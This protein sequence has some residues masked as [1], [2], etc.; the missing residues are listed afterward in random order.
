[1]GNWHFITCS[2]YRRLPFLGSARRRDLFL[3]ILE[4]T[5]RKYQFV[6]AGYVRHARTRPSSDRRTEGQESISGNA[7]S[8]AAGFIQSPQQET[9]IK[10][11]T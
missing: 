6:V 8:E 2:C 4:E 10:T 7:G 11:T 5:R 1:M 3:K 9:T